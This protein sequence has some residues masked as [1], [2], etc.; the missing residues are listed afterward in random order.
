MA[1]ESWDHMLIA[2]LPDVTA[3]HWNPTDG[4]IEYDTQKYVDKNSS[5]NHANLL[6]R[7]IFIK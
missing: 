6:A 5:F 4:G 2:K 7:A 1:K 3:R